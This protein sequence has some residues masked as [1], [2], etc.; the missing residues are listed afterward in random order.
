MCVLVRVIRPDPQFVVFTRQHNV[1]MG[2]RF[3]T[4]VT[5]EDRTEIKIS[6]QTALEKNYL[7]DM[8]ST[9][10]RKE[11]RYRST[12]FPWL[13]AGAVLNP[14]GQT[15]PTNNSM[16]YRFQWTPARFQEAF[17]YIVNLEARGFVLGTQMAGVPGNA[18]RTISL[19]INGAPMSV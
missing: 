19:E 18:L 8:T 17:T 11:S 13:P 6:R 7:V 16:T 1:T 14:L 2:C 4:D 10:G 5:A 12:P 9:G 15:S 3:M